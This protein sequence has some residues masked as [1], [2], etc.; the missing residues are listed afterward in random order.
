MQKEDGDMGSEVRIASRSVEATEALA[1]HLGRLAPPGL[2]VALIGELGSGK[3]CFVRGLSRGLGITEPV[4]SPTYTLMH[5]YVG[6]RLTLYHFDAWMEGREKAL[7]LDGGDDWLY[8]QG[9]SAVEW[10]GR[11]GDW[12]PEPRL[13]VVLEH[14]GPEARALRLTAVGA[15]PDRL[16]DGWEGIEGLAPLE[17]AEAP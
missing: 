2:V 10:A 15:L 13:E 7:F 8:A 11:V 3:T 14:R 9:V 1:E 4:S 16:L 5:E 6:G 17:S 12:L